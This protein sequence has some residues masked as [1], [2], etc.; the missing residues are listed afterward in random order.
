VV[1]STESPPK[2]APGSHK[3]ASQSL[4]DTI[5]K[6]RAAHRALSNAAK[7]LASESV[8]NDLDG[9]DFSTDD[10]FNQAIFGEGGSTKVLKQRIKTARVEGRLNISNLQLSEIPDDVYRMYETT[11]EDLASTANT[12]GPKWYE[13]VDLVRL[14]GADNEIQSFG[15]EL[16][17]QFGGLAS[18]DVRG[19][20][21]PAGTSFVLVLVD[22]SGGS[23]NTK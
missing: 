17:K 13:S 22:F 1:P 2:K 10:P 15:K 12:N 11:E 23:G 6:A 3:V 16:V 21:L 18:I 19:Q 14:V 8:S 5:A 9:F 4:R 20:R 7:P